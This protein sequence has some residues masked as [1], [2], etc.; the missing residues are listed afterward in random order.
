MFHSSR[1]KPL[2]NGDKLFTSV[3]AVSGFASDSPALSPGSSKYAGSIR[4][5]RETDRRRKL[6]VHQRHFVEYVAS[7]PAR[8]TH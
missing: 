3:G 5:S 7:F 8:I 6:R 4:T 1:L 2:Q